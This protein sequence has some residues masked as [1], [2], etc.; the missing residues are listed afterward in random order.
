MSLSFIACCTA[1]HKKE[2][3]KLGLLFLVQVQVEH[4]VDAVEGGGQGGEEDGGVLVPVNL[5][6][7]QV[8]L[9]DCSVR[10]I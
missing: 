1:Y 5:V 4:P 7:P 10:D 3:Q 2:P 8:V 6:V 9:R